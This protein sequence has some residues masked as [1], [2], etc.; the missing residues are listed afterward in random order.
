M[1]KLLFVILTA[2]A[3]SLP[4]GKPLTRPNL[5]ILLLP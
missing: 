2:T 3:L 5:A 4:A 1:R